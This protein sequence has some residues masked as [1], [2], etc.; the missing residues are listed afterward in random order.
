MAFNDITIIKNN[1]ALGFNAPAQD[2]TSGL[3]MYLKAVPAPLIKGAATTFTARLASLAEAEAA[4]ITN[5][6]DTQVVWYHIS[7]FFRICKTGILYLLLIKEGGDAAFDGNFHALVSLQRFAQGELRQCGVYCPTQ[8]F[9]DGTHLSNLQA[10]AVELEAA[11]QPLSVIYAPKIA[12]TALTTLP[13]LRKLT[14]NKVSVLIAQ[15]GGGLGQSL[16]KT[17]FETV[18]CIGACIGAIARRKVSESIAWVAEGNLVTTAYG[19]QKL[20]ELE[21]P[22]LSDGTLIQDIIP[23]QLAGLHDKGY[24]FLIKHTGIGGSYFNDAFSA[25]LATSD[26]NSIYANRTIDKVSRLIRTALLPTLSAPVKVN[27]SGQMDAGVVKFWEELCAQPLEQMK[28]EEEISAYA[29]IIDPA[30]NVLTE[31]KLQIALKIVPVGVARN[32]EVALAFA[33]KIA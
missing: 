25:D 21:Q 13:D 26:F 31:R 33:L 4:G 14:K 15:D 1:G 20:S 9:N 11:H 17:N 28:K 24:L 16:K 2:A 5:A 18:S 7:E 12:A 23:S 3:L 29:V 6:G 10:R 19:G 22:A 30:Q 27:D 32:I 8:A